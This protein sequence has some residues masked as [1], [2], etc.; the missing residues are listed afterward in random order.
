MSDVCWCQCGVVFLQCSSGQSCFSQNEIERCNQR[1][2][3]SL[4]SPILVCFSG[5]GWPV[6]TSFSPSFGLTQLCS[7][8]GPESSS[9]SCT[10]APT[11]HRHRSKK[12]PHY[13]SKCNNKLIAF[14][15]EKEA[16]LRIEMQMRRKEGTL[17]TIQLENILTH[18]LKF[19][20]SLVVQ[21]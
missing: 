19:K 7:A 1:R 20:Y 6:L 2:H 10:T 21:L 14:I 17:W 11:P 15:W 9:L 4:P 3:W 18:T 16:N 13:T 8:H 5:S 12:S